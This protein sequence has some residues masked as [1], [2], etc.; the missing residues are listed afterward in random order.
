[1]IYDLFFV[2]IDISVQKLKKSE[3]RK[4]AKRIILFY[5]CIE[6]FVQFGFYQGAY[7]DVF[8]YKILKIQSWRTIEFFRLHK[9]AVE[10]NL[11]NRMGSRKLNTL[12]P[13]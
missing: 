13:G 12:S 3:F 7:I 6:F 2:F 10:F 11:K 1:M 4:I 8:N 5:F 9:N